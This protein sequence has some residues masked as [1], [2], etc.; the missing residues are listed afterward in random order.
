[1][2]L[3]PPSLPKKISPNYKLILALS[4]VLGGIIGAA[5]VLVNNKIRKRKES[6]SKV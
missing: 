2:K 3:S 5:I 4:I 1:M 6:L